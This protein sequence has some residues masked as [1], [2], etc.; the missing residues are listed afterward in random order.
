MYVLDKLVEFSIQKYLGPLL[1]GDDVQV[2]CKTAYTHRTCDTDNTKMRCLEFEIR[3]VTLSAEE[4]TNRLRNAL[5]HSSND[6]TMSFHTNIVR[7]SI[8]CIVIHVIVPSLSMTSIIGSNLLFRGFSGRKHGNNN[9]ESSSDGPSP[10]EVEVKG[11]H[12]SLASISNDDSATATAP[13]VAASSSESELNNFQKNGSILFEGLEKQGEEVEIEREIQEPVVEAGWIAQWMNYA[14]SLLT[15]RVTDTQICV[16]DSALSSRPETVQCNIHKIF[17]GPEMI[18]EEPSLSTSDLFN[19]IIQISGITLSALSFGPVQQTYSNIVDIPGTIQAIIRTSH[20]DGN[21]H[22]VE[23]AESC[24]DIE[25]YTE[26]IDISTCPESIFVI[27]RVLA[28]HFSSET[29]NECELNDK[30]PT[31]TFE[32]SY[33]SSLENV[34][35]LARKNLFVGGILLRNSS[36]ENDESLLEAF[37]DATDKSMSKYMSFVHSIKNGN[38]LSLRFHVSKLQF[39][40]TAN[41]AKDE[42]IFSSIITDTHISAN[43]SQTRKWI[44]IELSDVATNATIASEGKHNFSPLRFPSPA[45]S[46]DCVISASN[47]LLTFVETKRLRRNEKDSTISNIE[48]ELALEPIEI[49]L[50]LDF[51]RDIADICRRCSTS[52]RG[53]G[54][55]STF[56]KQDNIPSISF[57]SHCANIT[58]FVPIMDTSMKKSALRSKLLLRKGVEVLQPFTSLGISFNTLLFESSSFDF[59]RTSITAESGKVFIVTDPIGSLQT[60][61]R[62]RVDLIEFFSE[63]ELEIES[64]V[65]IRGLSSEEV[66]S[67]YPTIP[68]LVNNDGKSNN[69]SGIRSKRPQENMLQNAIKCNHSIEV[70]FPTCI[71]D[72]SLDERKYL[73]S[74]LDSIMKSDHNELPMNS[75]SSE[76]ANCGKFGLAFHC[77]QLIVF[78]H[79]ATYESQTETNSTSFVGISD[80]LRSHFCFS[81]DGLEQARVTSHDSTLYEGTNKTLPHYIFCL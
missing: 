23:N 59:E 19:Q 48:V 58:V 39:Q 36:L 73:E 21:G 56:N 27:A 57:N 29:F 52:Y 20:S 6:N 67:T 3:N 46:S 15:V 35:S 76:N 16:L 41:T 75:D 66:T 9:G 45:E 68:S 38:T 37:Y 65:Q 81:T 42:K 61:I 62:E 47:V 72:I 33:P 55:K 10:L 79:E 80:T 7:A 50:H 34:E 5:Q 31:A 70:S 8:Q 25:I 51:I 77:Q 2:R 11:L 13:T 64:T 54:E 69:F 24:T 32:N 71:I 78:L 22:Q 43:I 17:Y 74:V 30:I 1:S 40:L 18:T 53:R 26:T 63:P 60:S 49:T 44:Q 12:V 4:L 28:S 14:L